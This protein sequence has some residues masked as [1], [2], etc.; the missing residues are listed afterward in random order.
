MAAERERDHF[1]TFLRQR[2]LRV[3]RER[4]AVFDE[5]YDQHRH[6]DAEE[7]LAA[8]RA[9]GRHVSRATVYRNLEL[10]VACGLVTRQHIGGH[11]RVYEHVHVGQCHDHLVCADCGRVVEFVSP[12]IAAL[13]REICRAHGFSTARH[14]LQI[15]GVC[16]ACEEAR[17]RAAA[18]RATTV[19]AS[20]GE[21]LE[22]SSH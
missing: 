22:C 1:L 12:G 14:Q 9:G 4:L 11:R 17:E 18:G 7:L 10:L 20:G 2:G 3:T 5:I 8:L 15:V 16:T 21:A 19:A 13:Q 6:I